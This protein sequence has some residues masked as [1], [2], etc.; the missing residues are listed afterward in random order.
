FRVESW[1]H[2]VNLTARAFSDWIFGPPKLDTFEIRFILDANALLA[3]LMSGEVDMIQS[4]GVRAEAA[5]IARDQR[6]A[7]GQGYIRT[8][9][10]RLSFL[11]IQF[12]D[13]PNRQRALDDLRVRQALME[14]VMEG[15]GSVAGAFVVPSD[16]LFPEIDRAIAHYPFDP[17]RA[18]ALLAE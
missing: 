8:W 4:P 2:G 5:A 1:N 14:A 9:E 18:T 12:R 6:V 3:N 13:V 10:T 16:P 7:R 15:L 11:D 17:N